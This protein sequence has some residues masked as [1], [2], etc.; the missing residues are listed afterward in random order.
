MANVDFDE[1]GAPG[2]LLPGEEPD[3][4]EPDEE[5]AKEMP[6][7][8]SIG[9]KRAYERGYEYPYRKQIINMQTVY[10][11]NRRSESGRV[12]EFLLLVREPDAWVA[13][14]AKR[15]GDKLTM[16]QRIFRSRDDITKAGYHIWQINKSA[17]QEQEFD[18]PVWGG[19][20][21]CLTQ[22]RNTESSG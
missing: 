18:D 1:E 11:C 22:V 9:T 15:V 12:N 13:C 21:M 16:R 2:G 3:E 6:E 4:E 19:S 17:T 10:V 20:L 14:D 5:Q 8:F 7:Y